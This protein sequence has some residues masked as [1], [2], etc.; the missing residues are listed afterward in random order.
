[1]PK[2]GP[3]TDRDALVPLLASGWTLAGDR[4]AITKTFRFADFNAAFGFMTRV[5]LWAERLDHHPEWSN[6]YRTVEVT[7][8]T[9]DCKGLSAL[10][11]SL[12]GKMDLAAEGPVR[13]ARP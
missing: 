1:M 13:A 4:D 9:H 7:L 8:T 10:D 5:A 6:V 3:L 2:T 12:A 11:V